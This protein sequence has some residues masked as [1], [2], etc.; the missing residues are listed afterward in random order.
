MHNIYL[1]LLFS[2]HYKYNV[3]ELWDAFYSKQCILQHII[4]FLFL[5]DCLRGAGASLQSLMN[6][7][8]ILTYS[9]KWFIRIQSWTA[10][11]SYI[12]MQKRDS[13]RI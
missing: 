8:T 6:I 9:W 7:L 10:A 12:M 13:P 5:S 11:G 1:Q 2:L 3:T 4:S